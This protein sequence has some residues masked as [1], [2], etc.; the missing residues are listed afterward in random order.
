VNRTLLKYGARPINAQAAAGARERK[1]SRKQRLK[2]RPAPKVDERAVEQA[3][4][5]LER[6]KWERGQG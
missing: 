1:K 5:A 4:W 6:A 3:R 2:K